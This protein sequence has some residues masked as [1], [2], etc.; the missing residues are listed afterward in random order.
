MTAGSHQR[1]SRSNRSRWLTISFPA[2]GALL[3]AQLAFAERAWPWLLGVPLGLLVAVALWRDWPRARWAGALWMA[4][5][6]LER[7][8]RLFQEGGTMHAVVGVLFGWWALQVWRDWSPRA[9]DALDPAAA[10][11]PPGRSRV[12]E[13]LVA[14]LSR[15]PAADE[16][17]V[18]AAFERAMPATP[19]HVHRHRDGFFTIQWPGGAMALRVSERHVREE[20]AELARRVRDPE[21]ARALREHEGALGVVPLLRAGEGDARAT[22]A[23]IGRFLAELLGSGCVAL[24]SNDGTRAVLFHPDLLPVLR[25]CT[26]WDVLSALPPTSADAAS[27]A[28]ELA[29]VEEEARSRFEEFVSAFARRQDD[30]ALGPFWVKA[31]LAEAGQVESL[32]IRVEAMDGDSLLGLTSHAPL[33]LRGLA[34][35][36][37]VEVERDRIGDW[38]FL[39]GGTPHGFFGRRLLGVAAT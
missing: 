14:L 16:A 37:P 8:V 12:P 28:A 27:R 25:S 29:A 26:P 19:A 20:M 34:C 15:V 11:P 24:G 2:L 21:L 13:H 18:R 33:L 38:F 31:P 39:R 10:A 6:G 5:W 32:W 4:G 3:C 22:E 36:E 30:A 7:L 35:G 23:V 9:G 17:W 1:S